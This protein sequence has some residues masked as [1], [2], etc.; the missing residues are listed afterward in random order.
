MFVGLVHFSFYSA[1]EFFSES[2][3]FGQKHHNGI[4]QSGFV[5]P[6]REIKRTVIFVVPVVRL[7]DM[8]KLAPDIIAE[9]F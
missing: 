4:G 7:E 6:V 8:A 2:R 5:A 1:V 3:D 9:D